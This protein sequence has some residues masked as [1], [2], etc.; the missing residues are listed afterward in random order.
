[1]HEVVTW[2]IRDYMY[3]LSAHAIS[4]VLT[5]AN[6]IIVTSAETETRQQSCFAFPVIDV[7]KS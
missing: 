5:L 6:L 3:H 7:N 1:M 2:K 4:L